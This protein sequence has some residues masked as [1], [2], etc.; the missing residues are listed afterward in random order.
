VRSLVGSSGELEIKQQEANI[1]LQIGAIW[2]MRLERGNI[3]AA[4]ASLPKGKTNLIAK[5]Q[6]E[7]GAENSALSISLLS[8][9][10]EN[11]RGKLLRDGCVNV[12]QSV[13]QNKKTGRTLGDGQPCRA[14][15][16]V[17]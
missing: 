1:N 8:L 7:A 13:K 14:A 16:V 15:Q 3:H 12:S 10:P 2:C 5:I 9:A 6:S 17:R 4:G 11:E